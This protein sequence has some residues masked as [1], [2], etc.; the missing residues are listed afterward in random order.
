MLTAARP[1]DAD[2]NTT[3]AVVIWLGFFC[4]SCQCMSFDQIARCQLL[5]K[6]KMLMSGQKFDK[7]S[8]LRGRPTL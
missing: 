3:L 7:R 8:S 6:I 5:L 4:L 1:G 2:A